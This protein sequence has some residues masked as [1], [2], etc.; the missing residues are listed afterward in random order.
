MAKKTPPLFRHGDGID[1]CTGGRDPF[2]KRDTFLVRIA[3]NGPDRTTLLLYG[4]L[5]NNMVVSSRDEAYSFDLPIRKWA[6]QMAQDIQE[7]RK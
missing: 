1:V 6:I 7:S 5:T 2:G 4:M 3:F